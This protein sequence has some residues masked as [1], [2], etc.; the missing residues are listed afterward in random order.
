MR[1]GLPEDEDAR[2]R[3]LFAG[4]EATVTDNGFSER[5]MQRVARQTWRRRV[6]L[7]SAGMAGIAIAAQP[8]WQLAQWLG[9]EVLQ[10]TERAQSL[11]GLLLNPWVL[12]VGVALLV[13]PGFARWLED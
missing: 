1:N 3:V 2:L 11:S 6:V 8:V 7:G 10:T 9:L 5:V 13:A 4:T 12:A